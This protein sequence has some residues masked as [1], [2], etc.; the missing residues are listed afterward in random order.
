MSI[1][2]QDAER[3]RVEVAEELSRPQHAAAT[4][5]AA[6]MFRYSRFV[7]VGP[8][9]ESCPLAVWT[10]TPAGEERP[11]EAPPCSNPEHFHAWVRLPNKFQHSDIHAKALA[12]KARKLRAMRDPESDS[13]VILEAEIEELRA[14][15][16]DQLAIDE[17]MAADWSKDYLAALGDVTAEE[18]WEHVDQDRE[19]YE[20]LL[21]SEG[22]KPED[23]RS[24]EFRELER[25]LE[26]YRTAI[27]SRLEEIQQP[28]R[29]GLLAKGH[30]ALVNLVRDQRIL[31]DG[32][33]AFI[34]TYNK[35]TWLSG[36]MAIEEH[37]VT[38]QHTRPYFP[39]VDDLEAAAPEIVDALGEAFKSLE[40]EIQQGTPGNS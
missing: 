9:A 38:K 13:A 39:S 37:P 35:W 34:D 27:H 17:L 28:A 26:A 16:D 32:D 24:E 23:E 1:A 19:Q 18:Q 6:R 7:H 10:T 15:G 20:R 12:A 33:H 11:A 30:D 36:T 40:A 8:D 29:D 2:E 25:H 4:V 21:A 22:V 3:E 14:L 5:V 31:R